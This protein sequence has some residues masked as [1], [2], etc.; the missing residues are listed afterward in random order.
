MN[1]ASGDGVHTQ[2]ELTP[3]LGTRV[4][5]AENDTAFMIRETALAIFEVRVSFLYRKEESNSMLQSNANATPLQRDVLIDIV[6]RRFI[7]Q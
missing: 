2:L 4:A 3:E 7:D 5:V 1:Q 6:A